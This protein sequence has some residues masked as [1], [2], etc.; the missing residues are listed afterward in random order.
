MFKKLALILPVAAL[1]LTVGCGGGVTEKTIDDAQKRIDVLRS[2]GLPDEQVSGARVHIF[3]ARE[4]VSKSNSR[5]AKVAMDSLNANIE[6]AEKFYQ[7]QVSNLGP[8]IDA[9]KAQANKAKEELSGYQVKKID[10]SFAIIDSFKRM[11]WLLQSNNVAQELVALLPSLKEDEVKSKNLRRLVPG[12]W[13]TETRTRSEANRDVNALER[14][15]FTFHRDG[16]VNLVESKKGQSGEFLKEDWEFRSWGTYDMK[17]DTIM[18]SINRFAAVRQMFRRIHKINDQ[19]VWKDEPG[20]VYDS[21][22]T[23][24]SQDRFVTFEDLKTDFK[25]AKRF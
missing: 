10:S 16:K 1:I 2:K 4:H 23:D 14:K 9:A 8:K 25:Q 19:M 17:G 3:S 12:E 21:A 24:G 13:V 7:D 22:I 20:P 11:D 18:L 5:L 6:R 15:V